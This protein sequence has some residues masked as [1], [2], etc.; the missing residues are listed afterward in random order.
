MT[1]SLYKKVG[2]AAAIMTGSIFISRFMGF[3]RLMVIAY[4]G[5]RSE[6]VDAYQ[7]AFVIPEILNHIIASGFLSIT[8]IPIFSRYLAAN[9]EEQGWRVFSIILTGFGTLLLIFIIISEA[10]APELVALISRGRPDP[11]FREQV[12]TMTRIVIPAQF[13]FFAGGLFMAVQFAKEKFLI[14]ALAPLLYN[15]GII[16]GGL[17]LGPRLG[18]QGFSWGVLAGAL[19]G[20]FA[21]QWWGAQKVGMKISIIFDFKHPDLKSYIKLTLPLMFGL[22]MFFSMEI[23]MKFFGAYLPEGSIADLEYSFRT[24]L[25]LV[26]FFGQA[27]G[28]ATYPFMARLVAENKM[29]EMNQLLNNTLKYLALVIPFSVLLMVLRHEVILVIFQRGKFDATA[30]GHTSAVLMYLLIGAFA[31]AANTIV[32]RAYYAVQD[33]LFPAVYGTGA[34]LLSIPIYLLGLKFMGTTGVA[35]AV[36]LSAILQVY[37]LY[38]MWNKR[39]RNPG[40]SGVYLFYLKIMGL[41]VAVGIVL[42][43][44]KQLLA[45][46]I[47]AT[48]FTGSLLTVFLTGVLFLIVLLVAGYGFGVKEINDLMTK[49][50]TR[51]TRKSKP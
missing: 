5:G 11:G 44:F 32:P 21:L 1:R 20:N 6:G 45:G 24:M 48:T 18:M 35:L 42:V 2:I 33:T 51:N 30:T 16:A 28:V 49:I 10:F 38:A 43:W 3:F 26:A 36:S 39:S 4:V 34:V 12:L 14:P 13:L 29:Q 23:F 15:L 50:L 47:E 9:Q 25:L 17:F 19:V 37:V 41:S 40:S 31:V 8:F 27:V 22:T 7:V 46:W